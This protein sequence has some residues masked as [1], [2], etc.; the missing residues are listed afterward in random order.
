MVKII[1]K[2][3]Q[4]LFQGNVLRY[5]SGVA[6]Q[7]LT[8]KGKSKAFQRLIINSIVSLGVILLP[9]APIALR[10]RHPIV[11]TVAIVM[12]LAAFIA[13]C[14]GIIA[15]AYQPFWIHKNQLIFTNDSLRLIN[16]IGIKQ[17]YH[18]HKLKAFT[19]RYD[20]NQQGAVHIQMWINHQK[21]YFFNAHLTHFAHNA[22]DLF[23]Q[24]KPYFSAWGFEYIDIPNQGASQSGSWVLSH[25]GKTRFRA[26]SP[27]ETLQKQSQEN[28]LKISEQA[29]VVAKYLV[30]QQDKTLVIGRPKNYAKKMWWGVGLTLIIGGSM[31]F[32]LIYMLIY[33]PTKN[34]AGAYVF[35]VVIGLL[36]IIFLAAFYSSAVEAFQLK[37]SPQQV[38]ISQRKKETC[39]A[40]SQIKSLVLE[41]IISQG[42][43][44]HVTGHLNLSIAKENGEQQLVSLLKVDSGR[45]EKLDTPLVR[46]AT[47]QRSLHLA[48]L[49]AQP[50]NLTIDWRGFKA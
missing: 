3:V 5:H 15:M 6:D 30:Q 13:F 1:K 50:M 21:A 39:Y 9:I 27:L 17:T 36:W 7:Q 49:I 47:Y 46:D 14:L 8:F 2:Y 44:T 29:E 16:G 48:Q 25:A 45:P 35:L 40:K 20:F 19:L 32:G 26:D 34:D 10:F 23:E 28:Q 31:I 43:Y 42:R 22:H 4:W 37:I 41:I 11:I 33:R 18:I 24:L 12:M 38:C